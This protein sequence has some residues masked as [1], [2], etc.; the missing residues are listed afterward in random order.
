MTESIEDCIERT[1]P[2]YEN[3]ILNEIKNGRNV[4]V[5]THKNCLRSLIK[6]IDNISD[7]NFHDVRAPAGIPIVY[8]FDEKMNPIKPDPENG[9]ISQQHMNGIFLE[10][11]ELVKAALA[12]QSTYAATVP[13]LN[14]TV[15][16][17]GG[18]L[19]T[20]E[21]FISNMKMEASLSAARN[22]TSL[23]SPKIKTTEVKEG[24]LDDDSFEE[25][26]ISLS[27]KKN[28]NIV[29][30]E[31]SKSDKILLSGLKEVSL[32][33]DSVVVMIRHGKTPHNELSLFTGWDD[34]PLRQEGIQQARNAGKLLKKNGFRFDVV[35]TSWLSR[36]IETAWLVMDEMDDMWLPTIK[37][38]RLNER[39]YGDLTNLSKKMIAQKYGEEQLKKWRRG[40]A[41]RPPPVSSF[42]TNYP[43]NGRRAK[44]IQDVRYSFTETLIRSL[45]KRKIVLHR[46]LPKTECLKDCMERTIPFFTQKI[47]P[48]AV[49]KGKRVLI[50][51]S[52]NAIRGLLMKLCDIPED[53]IANVNI[54][55]GVPLIYNVKSQCIQLLDDG[56][57]TDPLEQYDFGPA[58]DLLFKPC[59][60]DYDDEEQIPQ[61]KE[62]REMV[63]V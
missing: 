14:R 46:K 55:N 11:P 34:P 37:T 41:V 10:K 30:S 17:T 35:Y 59:L 39:M 57:G 49:N 47:V 18:R 56:S 19:S 32:K 63:G 27:A 2:L 52:E 48:E 13:G 58:S 54:P 1:K 25:K 26:T 53:Q 43:G 8:K 24:E 20:I 9:V 51:S 21:A 31:K 15:E 4:L 50:A 7:E 33:K 28:V 36:A 16:K 44:Y 29:S 62:E 6:L 38:W 61:S 40:Y 5:V 45:E 3:R 22:E 12:Q 60:I 23:S 42:S